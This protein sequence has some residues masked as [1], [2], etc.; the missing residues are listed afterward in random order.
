MFSWGYKLLDHETGHAFSLVEGYNAGSGGQFRY[1]G[2]W[3]IMGN[4]SG[5]APDYIAWNKWK[6][7]WL[8]D[9]EVDCV[10]SDGVTEHTLSANGNA[11]DGTS[12]KLVAIRTGQNTSLVAELR[13]PVGVDS[14]EGGNT[15]RYCESGGVLLYTVDSTLRNGLGVYKVLDAMPGSTGWGCRDEASIST[16]GRGQGRGPSHFEVPELGVI[17]DVTGLSA[18]GTRATLKVTRRDTTIT[19]EPA[20]GTAPFTTTLTGARRNAPA[21]AAYAWDFGDGQTA[22]GATT[23][24]T[25]ATPGRYAVKL[26]VDGATTTETVNVT[27]PFTGTLTLTGPDAAIAGETATFTAPADQDVTYEVFRDSRLITRQVGSSLTYSSPIATTDTVRACVNSGLACA[28][29]APSR[30]IAWRPKAGWNELWDATT[31][32]GWTHHGAGTIAPNSMTALGTAGGP[33]ALTYTA[34]AYK[35]FHLQ[36]KYRATSASNDG[37]VLVRGE[38]VAILDN[39]SADTRTGAIVGK[40]PAASAEAKPVREWNT[41]DVIARGDTLTSRVNGVE[42]ASATVAPGAGTIGLENAGSNVMYADVRILELPAETSVGGTVPATLSL[43]LGAPAGFGA[44]TPGLDRVYTASTTATVTS[45]AGDAALSA[46][47]PGHLMNGSFALPEPLQVSLSRAA[48]SA[49]VTGDAVTIGFTQRVNASDALRTGPYRKT[50]T[51]TLST[52]NP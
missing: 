44:F 1:M 51:F 32:A 38:Q 47:E 35:D 25:F 22:T 40:A 46:S 30:T 23:T 17:F 50:L 20:A 5:N 24:H 26:T 7:G 21:D 15:A 31:L 36:L 4:I 42:V 12:K 28:G 3:D 6:L 34:R 18:D 49:P 48:W 14:P 29:D 13:A 9:D 2:Q 33:G 52:T 11:P 37:G 27:A 41:L 45:T 43:T 8:D 19:A 39:G 16:M 10:A